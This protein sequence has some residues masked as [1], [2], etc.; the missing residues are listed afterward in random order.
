MEFGIFVQGH[1]PRRRLA[2]DPDY[3]HTSLMGD[4]EI[5]KA[6][7]RAGFKY[8]WVSEH[9]FLEEYSHLSASEIF[10]AYAAGV[11]E[12]IHVGS[13]I[14]N[15]NPQVNHPFRVAERVTMMDHLSDGR[16]EFGVG[17]GAGHHEVTGFGIESTDAT[18]E[19]L[20]EIVREIPKMFRDS[21]YEFHGRFFDAPLRNVLP[22]PWRKPHPPIWQACGNPPTYANVARKG[23]GAIGFNFSAVHE[24]RPMIDAYKSAIVD[25][26]PIGEY[27][28]N[29]VMITNTVV[30]L[31]DGAKAREV[32]TD[33]GT[34]LQISL[35][36]RYHT[37]FPK[38]AG[39]PE[40]PDLVRDAT[41][42]EVERRIK[43]GYLLCGE[44]DEVLEQV[45]R[46]EEV[47]ADQIVFSFP[48][49]MGIDV[50][51][52]SITLFGKHVIP[53][54]DSDPVHRTT[55][56]RDAAAGGTKL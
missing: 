38:P 40:W 8:A 45:K 35:V 13:A 14:W 42:E 50:A 47:G 55:R 23:L 11:T 34:G 49:D 39:I 27:V 30:C 56:F 3:E 1:V 9:H 26:E 46:Y 48:V 5:V 25:A 19:P 37:T 33:M 24:M 22:K 29:N 10:L 36:F 53:K 2:E 51:I 12:R 54:L 31:E 41:P 21:E 20:E 28:N 7:D 32:A 15:L 44:P 6:A 17:R 18:K 4:V 16:F 52:E 43:A